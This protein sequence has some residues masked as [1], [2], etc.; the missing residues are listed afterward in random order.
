MTATTETTEAPVFEPSPAL[1]EL[2]AT[3]TR[4]ER[5]IQRA[6]SFSPRLRI[7]Y[8]RARD[9]ANKRWAAEVRAFELA[10]RDTGTPEGESS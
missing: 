9:A 7:R 6:S 2:H 3:A 8:G 1:V 10:N 4:L 5:S